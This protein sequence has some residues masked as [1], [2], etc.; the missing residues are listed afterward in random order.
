MIS[1]I[2]SVDSV[3]MH[4]KISWDYSYLLEAVVVVEEVVLAS[5]Y[6]SVG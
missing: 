6:F 3:L 2:Y 5:E 4:G 1:M